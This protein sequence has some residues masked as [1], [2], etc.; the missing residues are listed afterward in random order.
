KD[1]YADY[2]GSA[3][4]LRREFRRVVERLRR[5]APGGRLLEIGCAYGYFLDE[6][7]PF[8]EC[9]GVEVAGDAVAAC[10]ARGLDVLQGEDPG[11][12]AALDQRGPF[13]AAVM[14]DCIEH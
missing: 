11:L 12:A 8:F 4:V 3:T 2:Q 10:R 14:L 1:G 9:T 7:Q 6:A 13:D 5:H